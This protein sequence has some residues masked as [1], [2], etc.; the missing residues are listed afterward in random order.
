MFSLVNVCTELKPMELYFLDL[1]KGNNVL[2]ERF[3]G[4]TYIDLV[5]I[6]TGMYLQDLLKPILQG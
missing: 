4:V 6:L 1:G 3:V 5:V 2:F